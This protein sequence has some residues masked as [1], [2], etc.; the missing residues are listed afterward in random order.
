MEYRAFGNR[1][2]VVYETL[3]VPINFEDALAILK[4]RGIRIIDKVNIVA[5]AKSLVGKA[6]W[7]LPSGTWEAPHYFDCSGFTRWLYGQSGIWIPRRPVQQ[8]EFCKKLYGN[9]P[10]KNALPADLLFVSSPYVNGRR[11]ENQ[12]KIGHVCIVSGERQAI[13]ATNSEFGTGVVEIT[14]D[15]LFKSRTLEAVGRVVENLS[16]VHTFLTPPNREIDSSDDIK[17]IILQS[18]PK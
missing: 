18:L 4:E 1:I 7:K 14:F 3:G 5:I 2:A 11:V 17:W 12:E 16:L 10:L 15:E 9:I 6:K 13:C 8:Y